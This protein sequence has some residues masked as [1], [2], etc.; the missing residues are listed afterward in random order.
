MGAGAH[1]G[2][3]K[4]MTRGEH[5][6]RRMV[7]HNYRH[8]LPEGHDCLTDPEFGKPIE[9]P[10]AP[11]MKTNEHVDEFVGS[12]S[13]T[14]EPIMG[15]RG[16]HTRNTTPTQSRCDHYTHTPSPTHTL[17]PSRVGYCRF[18]RLRDFDIIKGTP[19]DAMHCVPGQTKHIVKLMKG[20]RK[21]PVLPAKP[22]SKR[23]RRRSSIG[24]HTHTH[25]PRARTME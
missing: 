17:P 6:A 24:T 22:G 15:I 11:V 20:K 4:C 7:Y 13:R 18:S 3:T 5:I 1:F 2:C 16:R 9:P 21:L 8:L 25:T 14:G 19:Y 12:V 10:V 23:N